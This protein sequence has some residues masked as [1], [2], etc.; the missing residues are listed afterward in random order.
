MLYESSHQ[1]L[2]YGHII[3][4]SPP[5]NNH[6]FVFS[7]GFIS[8]K[9]ILKNFK[10]VDP[11]SK[12]LYCL[13]Q[14]Y[15]SFL[16]SGKKAALGLKDELK[17]PKYVEAN[18]Q[19]KRELIHDT[20]EKVSHEYKFNQETYEKLKD[21]PVSFDTPV[22]FLHIA[23]NKFL[24]CNF[25]EESDYEKE[26]FRLELTDYPSENTFL[27]FLPV[28][29]YQKRNEGV[30]Y[31]HDTVYLVWSSQ[32]LNKTPFVH[33][34]MDFAKHK[35][36]TEI[37]TILE[38][39]MDSSLKIDLIKVELDLKSAEN[40]QDGDIDE[41]DV[42]NRSIPGSIGKPGKAKKL[43]E[44]PPRK[45]IE[46]NLENNSTNPEKKI[47]KK[48]ATLRSKI[49]FDDGANLTSNLTK[50]SNLNKVRKSIS[51]NSV[52]NKQNRELQ[53]PDSFGV[54]S[55]STPKKEI[56]ISLDSKSLWKINLVRS[57]ITDKNI[58]CYG[59]I[60]WFNYSE[61]NAT[62]IATEVKPDPDLPYTKS[63]G[64]YDVGFVTS[65]FSDQQYQNFLGD[66]NG[67]WMIEHEDYRKGGMIEWGT[68][69]RLRHLISGRY[70]SV[71]DNIIG[72][73]YEPENNRLFEMVN[74]PTR[75][76]LSEFTILPTTISKA[77]PIYTKYIPKDAFMKLKH[78]TTKSW[79]RLNFEAEGRKNET[80]QDHKLSNIGT[81][82]TSSA[83]D[84]I[85][86]KIFK[87]NENEVWETNF[88]ISCKPFLTGMHEYM[89]IF[90]EQNRVIYFKISDR[91]FFFRNSRY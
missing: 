49:K 54:F 47:S 5:D 59:D 91:L 22:Q 28:Y 32:Y 12:Y 79:I 41:E 26:N 60:V 33:V 62:L 86:F 83:G 69:L 25:E 13:F 87:A 2:S 63:D 51:G 75:N 19:K 38:K 58:L 16:N 74:S 37:S 66:T 1:P 8:S 3:S 71:E 89:Q 10:T 45:K 23:S 29:T 72:Q 17:T 78:G 15:P 20:I 56:N 61:K 68:S 67:M 85:A 7:D 52:P 24:A 70:L 14:I 90:D 73:N 11:S 46:F 9:T 43:E 76:T 35:A 6:S 64:E 30:I 34:S 81:G 55:G 65:V 36:K 21:S 40:S 44:N 88:L 42:G 39:D 80:M 48:K 77:S 4:F 57:N 31:L 53:S 50:S 84:E 27:K 82:L 18:E